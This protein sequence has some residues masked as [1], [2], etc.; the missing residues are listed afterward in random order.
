MS[1]GGFLV[2]DLLASTQLNLHLI[3]VIREERSDG[4]IVVLSFRALQAQRIDVLQEKLLLLS[5]QFLAR[6]MMC[7]IE[8]PIPIDLDDQ[9][10]TTLQRYGKC[11][12]FV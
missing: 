1:S 10:D 12:L 8:G 9:I 2:G 11:S 6:G 4:A 7:K 3:R 5:S